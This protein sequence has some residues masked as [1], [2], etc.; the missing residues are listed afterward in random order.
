VGFASAFLADDSWAVS[1]DS[2][3]D[4]GVAFW[5]AEDSDGLVC[6]CRERGFGFWCACSWCE[7][8]SAEHGDVLKPF[9]L[10]AS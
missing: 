1:C 4:D 7:A 10:K 8:A 2:A 6:G 5:P 9:S 3:F